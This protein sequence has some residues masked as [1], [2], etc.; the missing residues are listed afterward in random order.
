M[1]D[2]LNSRF[3]I[4]V[5]IGLAILVSGILRHTL[6]I[7]GGISPADIRLDSLLLICAI[8]IVALLFRASR[9]R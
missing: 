8:A 3:K 7:Y 6:H 1:I 9:R 4:I 5:V 2:A